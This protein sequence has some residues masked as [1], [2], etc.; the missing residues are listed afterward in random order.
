MSK[1]KPCPAASDQGLR[2]LL[3]ISLLALLAACGGGS[4]DDAAAADTPTPTSSAASAGDAAAVPAPGATAPPP[5]SSSATPPAATVSAIPSATCGLAGFAEQALQRLNALR[6]AGASC[7]SRG[8]F[9]AAA[10][11][12]WHPAL[13]GAAAAHSA[14][15]AARDY[16]SH[17]APGGSGAGQRIAAAGYDART[18]AENIAAGHGSVEAVVAAWMASDGHC[19]NVMNPAMQDLGLACVRASGATYPTY[20]TMNLAA[21]R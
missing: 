6:A 10:P 5:P 15:M 3:A 18:W 1:R 4:G 11:L 13:D 2:P 16:F 7:G 19:A 8:S 21:V 20:W 9:K 14:D 12:A 17:T